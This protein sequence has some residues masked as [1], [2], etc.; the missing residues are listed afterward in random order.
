MLKSGLVTFFGF[1][2]TLRG[3]ITQGNNLLPHPL[4]G[5]QLY[6]LLFG[7]AGLG[8]Y[9]LVHPIIRHLARRGNESVISFAYALTLLMS[10][11]FLLEISHLMADSSNI[12]PMEI[13]YA[14]AGFLALSSVYF[15]S[16]WLVH[17]FQKFI[18]KRR[19]R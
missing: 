8:L 13:L 18:R 19:K 1:L 17:T 14:I 6:C 16:C 9:F 7:I 10:L 5:P 3:W 11:L 2:T 15:L 4:T 12:S